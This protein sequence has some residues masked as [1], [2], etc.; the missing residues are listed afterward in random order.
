M[1]RVHWAKM[2]PIIKAFSE[3]TDI[4][5]KNMAGIWS[6]NNDPS[7]LQNPEDYRIKREPEVRWGVYKG[8]TYFTSMD[9]K[10]EAERWVKEYQRWS[11]INSFV[12]KRLVEEIE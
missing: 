8:T 5:I 10:M 7:F 6:V 11:D 4:E 1:N 9:S 2:L 3:G 12:I